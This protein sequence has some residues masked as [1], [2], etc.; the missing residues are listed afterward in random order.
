[1]R[2]N[3]LVA[4]I[5]L[6]SQL[7][8]QD[9]SI[10]TL[11]KEEGN[12]SIDYLSI[13][14]T[15]GVDTLD[16]LLIE[17][18]EDFYYYHSVKNKELYFI[19]GKRQFCNE[20]QGDHKLN[21][22]YEFYTYQVDKKIAIKSYSKIDINSTKVCGCGSNDYF[23]SPIFNLNSFY[24]EVEGKYITINL[25][26]GVLAAVYTTSLDYYSTNEIAKKIYQK[27]K[28]SDNFDSC[29][30]IELKEQRY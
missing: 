3:L 24:I 18:D 15:S 28:Q 14:L 7:S 19:K 21:T 29:Y 12:Y 9:L 5:L 13:Q 2:I 30:R 26:E 16:S 4:F 10:D 22:Y 23:V 25:V 20:L 8:G 27:I 1:M 6:A 17:F 11:T